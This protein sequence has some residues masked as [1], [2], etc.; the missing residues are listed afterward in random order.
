MNEQEISTITV[1]KNGKEKKL[2]EADFLGLTKMAS[3]NRA[4][5]NNLIFRLIRIDARP[6]F[7]MPLDKREDRVC[8][9]IENG[10]VVK[11]IF[12]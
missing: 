11:A 12:T 9:E 4:E 10:E 1:N 5:S 8:I 7:S 2:T 3:Q 6:M